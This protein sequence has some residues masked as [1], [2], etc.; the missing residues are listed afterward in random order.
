M[1]QKIIIV[2]RLGKD[3]EKRFTPEGKAVTSFSVAVDSM[4]KKTA[5]FRVSA[6]DK[7]ADTCEQYLS[8]GKLVL[9]EGSLSFDEK[10]GGPRI[11]T[12]Q[13][14]EARASFEISASTVKFLSP[15]SGEE[16]F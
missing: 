4:D 5:W 16:T 6:W 8:K 7:L 10:S 9:V 15:K 13:S 1:Y 11:W 12:N 14:G 2:G 3:P